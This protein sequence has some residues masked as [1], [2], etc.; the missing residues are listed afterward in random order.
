MKRFV[1]KKVLAADRH[2]VLEDFIAQSGQ[3]GEQHVPALIP[4]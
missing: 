1:H 2:R 4:L 3:S